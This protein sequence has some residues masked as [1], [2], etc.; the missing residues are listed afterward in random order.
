MHQEQKEQ[1]YE[2]QHPDSGLKE[3]IEKLQPV[4]ETFDDRV[5]LVQDF[6]N[7]TDS[8]IDERIHEMIERQLPGVGIN[9]A[10][11][12]FKVRRN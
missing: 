4:M 3:D 7:I 6:T 12:L 9:G 1:Y 8:D 5:G 2:K 11:T 10:S